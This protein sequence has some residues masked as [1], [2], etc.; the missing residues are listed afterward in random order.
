MP[1]LG[2]DDDLIGEVDLNGD[3]DLTGDVDLCTGDFERSLLGVEVSFLVGVLPMIGDDVAAVTDGSFLIGEVDLERDLSL[4]FLRRALL[5]S[6][7]LSG[8]E[9]SK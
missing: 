3:V 4:I 5:F 2:V 7:G 8:G 1:V 6:G 9:D